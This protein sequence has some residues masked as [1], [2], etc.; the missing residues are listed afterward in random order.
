[1]K[2]TIYV[3]IIIWVFLL[4]F[5]AACNRD[6]KNA[7]QADTEQ[8]DS[9]LIEAESPAPAQSIRPEEADTVAQWL[10]SSILA[11]DLEFLRTEERMFLLDKYDLN[12]DGQPEYFV[13]FQND[14]FCGSGGCTYYILN[15]DGSVNSR[16]TVSYAPF[17]ILSEKT[18]GWHNLIIN[19]SEG[20]HLLEYDGTSY[21]GNP[22]LLPDFPGD[23]TSD[24]TD[25]IDTVLGDTK[26]EF[27]Y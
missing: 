14:Y 16:F 8:A 12:Q 19:S 21:P 11:E 5:F 13:G 26:Q 27:S 4:P 10:R 2:Q 20:A 15:H 6:G 25:V 3:N 17:R 22:T 24:G 7:Q 23:T 18:N 9:V 1:M